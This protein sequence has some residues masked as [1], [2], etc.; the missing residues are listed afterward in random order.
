MRITTRISKLIGTL[1][2]PKEDGSEASLMTWKYEKP[3]NKTEYEV[4]FSYFRFSHFPLHRVTVATRSQCVDTIR[5]GMAQYRP[6]V[7]Q[8]QPEQSS[9]L[10]HRVVTIGTDQSACFATPKGSSLSLSLS[11]ACLFVK[12]A[13]NS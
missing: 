8:C 6:G 3:K 4:C 7:S 1:S 9:I 11:Q 13:D 10:L 12:E 5:H 2:D